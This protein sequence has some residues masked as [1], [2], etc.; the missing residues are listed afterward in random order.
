MASNAS[1]RFSFTDVDSSLVE[2]VSKDEVIGAIAIRSPKGPLTPRLFAAGNATAIKEYYGAPTANWPDIIEAIDFNKS[3]P[4]YISAPAGSS[5]DFPSYYGGVYLTSKGTESFY[6]VDNVDSIEYLKS[7]LADSV[8]TVNVEF[9]PFDSIKSS[10]DTATSLA[11]VVSNIP[12][13]VWTKTDQ[14]GLQYWGNGKTGFE[15]GVK[16]F[17]IDKSTHKVYFQTSDGSSD[18]SAY[19]GVW[20]KNGKTYTIVLGGGTWFIPT[21]GTNYGIAD[22]SNILQ[23]LTSY[24]VATATSNNTVTNIDI[25]L[26]STNTKAENLE[27]VLALAV[28]AGQTEDAQT[29][30]NAAIDS[31][32]NGTEWDPEQYFI[33][34][35]FKTDTSIVALPETLGTFEGLVDVI[36]SIKDDAFFSVYQ[37][38][39]TSQ[40]TVV[41]ISNIGY[42]KYKYDLV[43]PIVFANTVMSEIPSTVLDKFSDY[44]KF[45]FVTSG[46]VTEVGTTVTAK[47][48]SFSTTD[49]EKSVLDVATAISEASLTKSILVSDVYTYTSGAT[50]LTN[51]SSTS[52]WYHQILTVAS[53]TKLGVQSATSTT[54]P[55]VEASDYNQ[56]T[57]TCSEIIDGETISGGTFTGSLSETG[58][59]THGNLIFFPNVLN[60]EDFSFISIA[61][62]KTFD[63]LLDARG[64]YTGNRIIDDKLIF[65]TNGNALSA[66]KTIYL[67]GQRWMEHSVEENIANDLEGEYLTSAQ[68]SALLKSYDI[69]SQADYDDVYLYLDPAGSQEIQEKFASIRS[70]SK[71]G[72]M[73]ATFLSNRRLSSSEAET[74]S[75]I[76][77]HGQAKGCAQL[78]N[79]F[80][81]YDSSLGK[82]Y[83]RTL[84]G[85]YGVKCADIMKNKNGGAAP[86]W[87]D[88]NG[89]GGQLSYTGT[90]IDQKWKFTEDELEIM[91]GKGLNPVTL[92]QDGVMVT[93][94]KTTYSPDVI[95]DWS[96]L[97]HS[98]SFDIFK[99]N[100][101]DQ[102]M[103]PQIM[104]PINDTFMTLRENQVK[105]LISLRTS[106]PKKC[107]TEGECFIKDARIN[108]DSTKAQ[109]TF[110]ILVRVKVEPLTE[111][112]SL[113]FENVGQTMSVYDDD[114][115]AVNA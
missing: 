82:F 7:E 30:W 59:D 90:V 113:T 10:F 40:K 33:D 94:Q 74:V 93:S 18:E 75:T 108:N 41:K 80:K 4:L 111:K 45:I 25:P 97:A 109:R 22:G 115:S 98:M 77:V 112:I 50:E 43:A 57:I 106:G 36:E 9:A 78:V 28:N 58:E 89:M 49:E 95:S 32:K 73:F 35:M 63:D 46:D 6:N 99:R 51:A 83:Y 19:V 48:Y 17:N 96:Y 38:S 70:T 20:Y 62:N 14:I 31:Y 27:K 100:V 37:R 91:D 84:V 15:A 114:L 12:T 29:V 102:V 39:P 86:A 2:K 3:Y 23:V 5:S 55:L 105:D 54:Y 85:P 110:R 88:Y 56:L 64:I 87:M 107:W 71:S 81:F 66:S 67:Q 69:Y 26:F 76:V 92:D 13:S 11:F 47:Y 42:D 61:V 60:D 16:Y 24:G 72:Q 44:G 8:A 52:P 79:E 1:W 103:R 53:A 101:R 68:E 34:G 21:Y 65:D 104:K